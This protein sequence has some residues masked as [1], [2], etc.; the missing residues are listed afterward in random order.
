MSMR[1]HWPICV[2]RGCDAE[3]TAKGGPVHEAGYASCAEEE[4]FHAGMSIGDKRGV[5]VDID[6]RGR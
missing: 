1:V 3:R 6:A 4:V 2:V 5:S